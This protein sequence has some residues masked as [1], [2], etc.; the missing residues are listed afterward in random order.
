MPQTAIPV[1]VLTRARNEQ[2]CDVDFKCFFD[3]ALMTKRRDRTSVQG[4]VNIYH[5]TCPKCK[6]E[7]LIRMAEN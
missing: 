6:R 7:G 1:V 5:I 3:D 2:I 4:S